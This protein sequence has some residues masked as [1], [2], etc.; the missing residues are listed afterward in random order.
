MKKAFVDSVKFLEDLLI[1]TGEE[2]E[3]QT[4]EK[5]NK[6]KTTATKMLTGTGPSEDCRP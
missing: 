4:K 2:A 6:T 3:V 5:Q 1:K